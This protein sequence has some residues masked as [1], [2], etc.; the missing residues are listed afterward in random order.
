MFQAWKKQQQQKQQKTD[1]SKVFHDH[2]NPEYAQN[3]PPNSDIPC[4]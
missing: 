2:G 3:T 1:I 4:P